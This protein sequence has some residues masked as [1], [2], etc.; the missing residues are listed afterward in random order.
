MLLK[1]SWE[2]EKYFYK[3]IND[4]N[5]RKDIKK[6]SNKLEKFIKKYKWNI[7]NFST[8]KDLLEFYKDEENLR[9]EFIKVFNYLFYLQSL[10][11]QN[12]DVI[13]KILEIE[14]LYHQSEEKISFVDEEFKK[15]FNKFT[16]LNNLKKSWKLTDLEKNIVE[17][18]TTDDKKLAKLNNP[19]LKFKYVI[20]YKIKTIKYLLSEKEEQLISKLSSANA[21]IA[22][23]YNEFHSWLTFKICIN[24]KKLTL[25][26]D[27]IRAL[28]KHPDQKIRKKAYKSLRKTYSKNETKI[29]L[30]NLYSSFVKNW[31]LNVKIRNYENVMEPRNI[32]EYMDNKVVDLLIKEV[33]SHYHLFQRYVKLKAKLLNKKHPINLE[34]LLAPVIKSDKNISY[35]EAINI[36]LNVM[37]SFDKDFYDYSID[38]LK[39]WRVDFFPKFWKRWWAYASYSK[40]QESF[41][42]LNFTNKLD[43]IFTLTHEF[44]H[45]IHWKLSQI[46]PEQTYDSPLSLAETA[47]IFNEMLVSD[48]LLSKEDIS[49]QDKIYLLESKLWDIFATIFRQIQYVDFEKTIHNWIYNWKQF[50]YEDYCKI[51]RKTQLKMSW[52]TIKYD[53]KEN[54]EN[55]WA[56]ISHIFHTPFYCYSYA[57]WNILVFSLFDKYKKEWKKFVKD[58][59]NILSSWW[60]IPPKELLKKFWIDISNKK[61]YINAFSQIEKML[62]ELE[63]LQ[64]S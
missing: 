1:T 4:S 57:F 40:N 30:S 48:Y 8:K 47:S 59:K 10:D 14:N 9:K 23:L 53:V 32:S 49:K 15:L 27:E 16:D 28:R 50:S 3:W 61:F 7:Q 41:V 2:L 51:R 21:Q 33:I 39:N 24:W 6:F 62:N 52:E 29:V 34:D 5:L 12:Q 46:Q 60:S 11:S 63:K 26:E 54:E 64:S 35:E 55:S 58:Y 31:I 45:A 43:D 20:L 38:L 36:H 56:M 17:L 22:N 19:L 44:W 42:L 37:K 25:T 13:K 18:I